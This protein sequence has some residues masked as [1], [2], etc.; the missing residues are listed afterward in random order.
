MEHRQQDSIHGQRT[1]TAKRDLV[2]GSKPANLQTVGPEH[3]KAGF[4]F[5]QK[6]GS[7]AEPFSGWPGIQAYDD[8]LVAIVN[9]R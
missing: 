2:V 1:M 9:S 6:A 8:A 3:E 7:G 5:A 4:C